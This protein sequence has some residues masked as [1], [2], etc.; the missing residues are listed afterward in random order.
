MVRGGASADGWP[1]NVI[2]YLPLIET[3][4]LNAHGETR[5]DASISI[6]AKDKHR[7]THVRNHER[8][9][10]TGPMHG[11]VTPARI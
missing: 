9:D 11:P 6:S 5:D 4:L 7:D 1:L 3:V 8:V 2:D 10:D